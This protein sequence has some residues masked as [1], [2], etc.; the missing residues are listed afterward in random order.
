MKFRDPDFEELI[1]REWLVT[2]GIGGYASSTL[3]GAHT[4]RYHALLMASFHPPTHRIAL[5]SKVE[6]TII[7]DDGRGINLSS[8]AFPGVVH[9]QGYVYL[10]SFSPK[11]FPVFHY[12]AENVR[13]R[14][15]VWMPQLVNATVLE[16]QNDGEELFSMQLRPFFVYREDHHLM[17]ELSHYPFSIQWINDSHGMITAHRDAAPCYFSFS[18]GSYREE[19]YWF[20]NYE[21]AKETYRG[22]DDREDTL[23]PGYMA[24]NLAPGEMVRLTFSTDPSFAESDL[25]LVYKGTT[26]SLEAAVKQKEIK[27][28]RDGLIQQ[29]LGKKKTIKTMLED[30]VSAGQ[31]FVVQR[32]STGGCTILAG[33]PW[34]TDWGRDTMIAMRGLVIAQGKK[35]LA[36][37]IIRTFVSYLDQ[38]MLPNRFPDHGDKPEYNTI[39]ATLWLFIVLHEYYVKFGDDKLIREVYPAMTD[40]LEWHFNGTRFDIHVTDEGLLYGGDETTQLTWMDAKVGDHIVTPRYGCAV[41]INA[42]WYN[43]LCIYRALGERM[44]QPGIDVEGWIEKLTYH[45][46]EQ[47]FNGEYLCDVVIPGKHYDVSFRPNQI[48]AMSLPFPLLGK[49][50]EKRILELM[51]EK[52]VTSF[53]LRTLDP[54]HPDFKPVYGGNQWTRDHAYHQGTVWPFLIG[55]YWLAFLRHHKYSSKAKKRVWHA[56][57]PLVDHF[58]QRDGIHMIS[59]IFDGENPGPGRGCFHQAWSVGMLLKVLEVIALAGSEKGKKKKG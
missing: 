56:M 46:R 41:E 22:L 38:G 35:E 28:I 40:I 25:D 10:K 26:R 7:L 14:K 50:E 58:Y 21:Y 5:V 29:D 11:P 2:N 1:S 52:L 34:F 54:D 19:R 43:A 51:E 8:N 6:E 36:G 12:E 57:Q 9:P 13:I 4:R 47:F 45:F 42:L 27:A 44:D 32:E 17:R 37:S 20:R 55:E 24:V 30:L 49:N 39:D 16:Y 3:A 48:Y 18:K 31:Q 59:E 53:G 15:T 33:Y 23:S